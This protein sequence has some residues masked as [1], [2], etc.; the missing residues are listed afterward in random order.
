MKLTHKAIDQVINRLGGAYKGYL[1]PRAPKQFTIPLFEEVAS[2]IPDIPAF[3]SCRLKPD[4]PRLRFQSPLVVVGPYTRKIAGEKIALDLEAQG[5]SVTTRVVDSNRF[6]EVQDLVANAVTRLRK[7]EV[8][9]KVVL[10]ALDARY[11]MIQCGRKT[12]DIVFGIGGGTVIDVA[13]YAAFK[14]NLPFVSVPTSLAN[15]G[16]ASPF[17]VLNLG[18]DG[19]A[20]LTANTPMAVVVDISL[21]Q[22]K[23]SGYERRMRSGIGDLLSN[24][25][26]IEDWRLAAREGKE[27]YESTSGYQSKSAAYATLKRCLEEESPLTD[28]SFIEDLGCALIA[29]AAAMNRCGSSRPASGFDHKFYHAYNR[30]QGFDTTATHGELVAVGALISS[31]AHGSYVKELKE[32]YAKIGLP[33]N[34]QDL[35][36]LDISRQELIQAIREAS[37]VKT[38]RYTILEALGAE[39]MIESALS[40]LDE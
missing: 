36:D 7:I 11:G 3:I 37:S 1:K 29:S 25:T 22:S 40:V 9:P 27:L 12:H 15:D 39:R 19:V 17:S 33:V 8:P 16:F 28:T 5:M 20:T 2:H 31:Q 18:K 24:L 26:A 23:D 10:S 34:W 35:A 13:K 30:L 4:F 38:D 14:L 21:I 32:V 6:E